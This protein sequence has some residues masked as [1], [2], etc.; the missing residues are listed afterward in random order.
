MFR[1][2]FIFLILAATPILVYEAGVLF[3]YAFPPS[4]QSDIISF[5]S[6]I[7]AF[8]AGISFLFYELNK[9]EIE[10]QERALK[11]DI[12]RMVQNARY[13]TEAHVLKLGGFTAF[14]AYMTIHAHARILLVA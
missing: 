6:L 1:Y 3:P 5:L 10:A 4:I 7:L 9:R 8:I 13:F 2:A 12:E 14:N 11:K